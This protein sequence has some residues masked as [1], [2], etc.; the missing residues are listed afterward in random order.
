MRL[1]DSYS[2]RIINTHSFSLLE[3]QLKTEALPTKDAQSSASGMSYNSSGVKTLKM[4]HTRGCLRGSTARIAKNRMSLANC[5]CYWD[6]EL[7]EF[8]VHALC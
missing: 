1:R 4:S 5:T 3:G 7:D 6:T 8:G 2:A